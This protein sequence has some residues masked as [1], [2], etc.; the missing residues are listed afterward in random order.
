MALGR[1]GGER[2]EELWVAAANLPTSP[3]HIFYEKLNGLLAEAGFADVLVVD[4]RADLN[5]YAKIEGQGGCC[6]PAIS[7]EQ[8]AKQSSACCGPGQTAVALAVSASTCCGARPVS[9][10]KSVHGG[11]SEVLERYDV[12]D[13]AASVK[14]Y[15]VK[16]RA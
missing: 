11:L 16:P 9:S 15:A 2:Q 1:R 8:S 4:S 6:S 7:S 14:V 5:A 10:Q 12:N 3:G 13:Y